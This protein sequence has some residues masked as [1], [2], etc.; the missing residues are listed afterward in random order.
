LTTTET[1]TQS[2]RANIL[3]SH[4]TTG[5]KHG[6][7]SEECCHQANANEIISEPL[8]VKSESFMTTEVTVFLLATAANKHGYKQWRI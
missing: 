2:I 3:I 7:V 6:N 5:D 1:K 8:P 4:I